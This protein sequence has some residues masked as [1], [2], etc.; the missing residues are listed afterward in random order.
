MNYLCIELNKSLSKP[1]FNPLL[2][3]NDIVDFL[4]FIIKFSYSFYTI[5]KMVLPAI[6]TSIL[7]V[8]FFCLD[9]MESI[10]ILVLEK[11]LWKSDSK[12]LILV[13]RVSFCL[14]ISFSSLVVLCL[15]LL[16]RSS[17]YSVL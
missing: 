15:F 7:S 3:S 2:D 1:I 12:L 13:L 5:V 14:N 17:I 6:S 9:I 4:H 10:S 16:F 11:V 8:A